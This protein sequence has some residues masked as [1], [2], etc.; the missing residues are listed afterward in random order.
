MNSPA[1]DKGAIENATST[2]AT[3][4]GDV[5]RIGWSRTDVNVVVDGMPFPPAAG[6]GSWAAFTSTGKGQDAIVM[7]DTVLFQDEVDAAIDAALSHQ[8]SVTALHNHFFYDEPKVYFMHINGQ[9]PAS[10]LASAVKSVWDAVK[11]VRTAAAEPAS[12][13]FGTTPKRGG[14]IDMERIKTLTGLVPTTNPGGVVKISTGRSATMDGVAIGG[15]MGLTS[16]AAFTGND[17][18]AVMDGD[19]I[20]STSEVQPVLNALRK[21]NLHIVALHNHMLGER[22]AYF[23]THFWGKGSAVE[24]AEGFK[25]VLEVQ[26]AEE[27]RNDHP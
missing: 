26:K 13:F 5:L 1:L 18:F 8:L 15:S 25:A 12:G 22:P 20:M 19:L 2:E 10:R 16:W 24:L 9:G 3:V 6:L 7:G 11:A 17:S 4:Q 27:R 14:K 21:A 23:F